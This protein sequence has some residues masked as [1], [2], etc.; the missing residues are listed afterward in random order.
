MTKVQLVDK[1]EKQLY[2]PDPKN[3]FLSDLEQL[4]DQM[5]SEGLHNAK[6]VSDF[7]A[8]ICLNKSCTNQA[9]AASLSYGD[10]ERHQIQ[11][12]INLTAGLLSTE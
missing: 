1:I 6:G 2:D 7:M 3:S 9:Q 4:A 10:N 5:K 8:S 11:T 12:E